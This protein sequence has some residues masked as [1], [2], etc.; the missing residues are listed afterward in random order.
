MHHDAKLLF[1]RY[2]AWACRSFAGVLLAS[3]DALP[4]GAVLA[5]I[6]WLAHMHALHIDHR[7]VAGF[8]CVIPQTSLL[9]GGNVLEDM[10]LIDDDEFK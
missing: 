7:A 2:D 8:D 4:C 5:L 1:G 9:T 3:G 6:V 10:D